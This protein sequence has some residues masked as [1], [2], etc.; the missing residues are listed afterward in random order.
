MLLNDNDFEDRSWIDDNC[1]IPINYS[2]LKTYY[3]RAITKVYKNQFS[4]LET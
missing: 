4:E 3:E 2:D 1:Y